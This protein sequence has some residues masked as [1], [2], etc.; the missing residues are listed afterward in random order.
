MICP[1]CGA[2]AAGNFCANCGAPLHPSRETSP[3]PATEPREPAT[4]DAPTIAAAI[5]ASQDAVSPAPP[6]T[7]LCPACRKGVLHATEVK[8]LLRVRH[9]LL[10]DRCGAVL[11]DHGGQPKLLELQRTRNPLEPNWQRFK[12][13]SLTALEWQRIAAGGCSDAEQAQADLAAAMLKLR[14]GSVD[15]PTA[16][17]C[18]LPLQAGERPLFVLASIS[19]QEPRGTDASFGDGAPVREVQGITIHCATF[20]SQSRALLRT[21]DQ[22]V[23]VL[24]NL[25]LCFAGRQSS[26]EADLGAF[27]H[28]D[29]YADALA[30]RRPGREKSEFF[31]GLE[32]HAYDFQVEGRSCSE[33]MSGLI[34]KYAIEGLLAKA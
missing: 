2:Q 14:A 27:V 33:P 30:V 13:Q 25:R 31:F 16:G 4:E 10:C 6:P 19:L 22:G 11:V 23:L 5:A 1:S 28:L 24:T 8:L 7:S 3:T 17:N 9:E 32:R 29:A 15:L 26:L 21:L 18:A 34:L 12:H 20:R